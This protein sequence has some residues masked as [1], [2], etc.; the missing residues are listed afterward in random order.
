MKNCHQADVHPISSRR[1]VAALSSAILLAATLAACGDREKE[2]KPGQALASVN[3]EEITVLQLNEEI[4]RAG[5]PAARQQEA[6]K[7]LLQALIDRQLLASA[8][9]QEKLDR[10]PKVVQAIERARALIVAQAYMQKRLANIAR[11]TPAEVEE[12]FNKHPEF[13]SKRKQL[14][15][16]QLVLAAR[17]LTPE[18]RAAADGAKSLEEVAVWLDA[19]KVKYG[20]AQVTRSTSD[21]N[22]EL[23]KKLLGMPQNQLFSVRE[24]ERAMLLAVAEVR[25]APVSLEVAAPQIEKFLMT[26]K[27]KEL[28]AAEVERLRQHAKIEYLNKELAAGPKAAPASMAAPGVPAASNVPGQEGGAGGVAPDDAAAGAPAVEA[29]AAAAPAATASPATGAPAAESSAAAGPDHAAVDRGVAG[30]K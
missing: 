21:L 12:Y 10:D 1:R 20:R 2:S 15:M 4:Q 28:A 3:G 6:S 17:D 18:T 8:A 22:P 11:P 19:H 16:D 23:S 7:Q 27:N 29:P 26:N 14:Q 9:A 24:G 25:D 30:L 13:F 5:V